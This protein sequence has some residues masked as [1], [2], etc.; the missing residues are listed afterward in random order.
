MRGIFNKV[1]IF[2]QIV[3]AI[4]LGTLAN[5]G[6][7]GGQ[8]AFAA[9]NEDASYVRVIHASPYVGTA[10]VF[11][12]GQM[13][14]SSFQFA[15]VTD[16]AKLPA[17]PHKVQIALLG[18][19]V[20]LAALTKELQVSPGYTY[21]VAAV[22]ATPDTLDLQVFIDNNQVVANHAKVRIYHL[23]PNGGAA[24]AV[25]NADNTVSGLSY[26]T[27]SSYVTL[28][29]GAYNIKVTV[30]Q[31]NWDDSLS[32]NLDSNKV[33]SI[34]AV[35]MFNG[36]PQVQLVS[37]DTQGI[38]GLPQTGSQPVIA[39]LAQPSSLIWLFPLIALAF[40]GLTVARY[41]FRR[42]L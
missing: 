33:T 18:K 22:G 29:T 20:G 4:M 8:A 36:T 34:F 24:N 13:F 39:D 32:T 35:G 27:A 15:T 3:L 17:G 2:S 25:I 37:K 21:T 9:A 16:Y 7:I 41:R 19:G 30:P 40:G 38:P 1:G 26:E 11:V 5:L 6:M 28:N 12:D 42:K 23:V 31:Q 14:L 10:D